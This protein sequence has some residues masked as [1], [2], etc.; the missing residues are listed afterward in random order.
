MGR[1][2]EPPGLGPLLPATD[3]LML[4]VSTKKIRVLLEP[5]MY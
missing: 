3:L 1:M 4:T 5:V 2:L